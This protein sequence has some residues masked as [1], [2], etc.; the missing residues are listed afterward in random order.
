VSWFSYG[1]EH[2]ND[3]EVLF[4]AF[5]VVYRRSS[6]WDLDKWCQGVLHD[7]ARAAELQQHWKPLT[8]HESDHGW[9]RSKKMFSSL[10]DL[11]HVAYVE[12]SWRDVELDA[13]GMAMQLWDGP[14]QHDELRHG[15]LRKHLQ[16]KPLGARVTKKDAPP[17]RYRTW[18]AV[19]VAA[20]ISERGVELRAALRLDEQQQAAAEKP[21]HERLREAEAL[22]EALKAKLAE[23][24]AMLRKAKD[25][26]GHATA[27][28][29]KK[30]SAVSEAK[31]AVRASAAVKLEE[32]KEEGRE[33][34]KRQRALREQDS[35]AARKRLA[36]ERQKACE[37]AVAMQAEHEEHVEDV[38][39]EISAAALARAEKQCSEQLAAAQRKANKQ[40]TLKRAESAQTKKVKRKLRKTEL[41]LEEARQAADEADDEMDM[42][43]SSGETSADEAEDPTRRRLGFDLVPRRAENGRYQAED[44]DLRAARLAQLARG[45]SDS[46]VSANMED[47]IQLT[48][49][50]AKIP[51]PCERTLRLMRGEVTIASEAMAAWKFAAA[52]R[53]LF[54]G[55]DES[56][57]FGDSIFAMT[58]LVEHFD[59]TREEV[60]LRGVTL[61]PCG[62]T[63]KAIL[64]HV[65]ER[66]FTHSRRV[67]GLWR[68]EFEKA[69]GGGG[70]WAAAGGPSPEQIGL[71]RLCEDTVL[72][73]DTCNAARCTRR[74]LGDAIMSAMQEKVGAAAWEAMS[75]E[76]RNAKYCFY[77]ADCWQH[78]R[79]IM[80]KAMAQASSSFLKDALSESLEQFIAIERIEVDAEAV[81]RAAFKQFH[82]G[83]EYAKGRG[84]EFEAWR[85]LMHR[86]GFWL[87]F[88]R[89]MGSRQDLAF[90]GCVPLY[91]NRLVCLEF[92]RGY[93]DCPKSQNVLDKSLYT[94]LRCNEFVALLRAHALWQLLFSEPF[95]WLA[96]KTGKLA[97]WSLYNM[98]GVLDLVEGAMERLATEPSL[99]LDSEF[100][101]F[102]SVAAVLPEFKA[103]R[104]EQMARTVLAADGKTEHA[105]YR[106]V[107]HRARSPGPG[108]GDDQATDTTLKLIQ[109][110]AR[111]ALEK[112][113][114]KKIA[115]ADKLTSQGGVNAIGERQE[116]LERTTGIDGTNDRSENK[117]AIADF[118][119]RT[120]RGISVLNVSGIVQQR[121]A[122]DFDRPVHVV[123]D[124]RKR[125]AT[126]ESRRKR[127]ATEESPVFIGGFFWRMA[128]EMRHAL[129]TMAR[130]ELQPA[131]GRARA[132]RRQHD[133]EKLSKREQAVQ[134]RLNAVVQQYA[135]A[136]EHFDVWQAQRWRTR[137]DVEAGLAG[138]PISS[139]IAALRAQIEARTVGCGWRHFTAK[140]SFFADERQ[141]KF[142][143][144]KA[145]L[146]D[147]ILPYEMKLQRKKRLPTEAAPPQL[148]RRAMKQL[149]VLDADAARLDQQSIFDTSTLLVKAE[150]AR[151]RREAA[152]ISDGVEA[153]QQLNAPPLDSSLVGKHLEV[154]WPYKEAGKTRKIWATGVVMRV[155]D[156]LTD[157][158]SARCKNFLPAGA[159][160]WAWEA[161]PE[162]DE[163]AGEEWLFLVPSKWNAHVQYAWRYDP[164]ELVPQGA[165]RPPPRAPRVD[166]VDPCVTDDEYD[167]TADFVR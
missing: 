5:L 60:C 33:R 73:T 74:L 129:V 141:H 68:D 156:G 128:R 41:Q 46:V 160:L 71:H 103:W 72:M 7:R 84:R 146:L 117:F 126:E 167:H 82:H 30:R 43:C 26:L 97:D 93:I 138:K 75:V 77:K 154:C 119:M 50:G 4:L 104:E 48:N 49:P 123:S 27:R 148:S 164:C 39:E 125:K 37:H 159:V 10:F 79:N 124:R 22:S 89:S 76:E 114:D 35:E 70:S 140:W 45:V 135:E 40:A 163:V 38:I 47:M 134:S 53:V 165:C 88:E 157:K 57:K 106:E 136:L 55:W 109:Q 3:T 42:E 20:L 112:L 162:Y 143:L 1:E 64:E 61:L 132:E 17:P 111:R 21:L 144:L 99:L 2:A 86:S 137:A 19:R 62:G 130:H 15:R 110:M 98:S 34:L 96:G 118:V 29:E 115:L 147:D 85:A 11:I 113:H 13:I 51:A 83:G 32:A 56:T 59:G 121:S 94:L 80:I 63:A 69:N 31:S 24:E 87:P 52:K 149:G 120:Y 151:A 81:I 36:A 16:H 161:D 131:I 54:A 66:I 116:A 107:L 155:A 28:A 100:D 78:L 142:D 91:L 14:G 150:A 65:E 58:F 6:V 166:E 67:L 105:V 90:D 8:R 9:H 158:R 139:Q 101:M 44:V 133:E 152:G 102:D 12:T 145:M 25:A 127:K 18:A 122:H 153:R 92:L 95:R 23:K 108:S